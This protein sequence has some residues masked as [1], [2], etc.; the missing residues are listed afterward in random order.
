MEAIERAAILLLGVGEQQAAHI[1]K[2]MSSRQVE[3]VVK[4]MTELKDITQEQIDQALNEFTNAS[5][6][7]TSLG[8]DSSQYIRKTLMGA[9]GNERASLLIDR[10]LSD[11]EDDG[12]NMLK[13]QDAAAI[14]ALIRDEHPQVIAVIL[15]YLDSEKAAAVMQ[16]LPDSQRE[17]IMP[18]IASMRS[19]SPRALQALNQ[20]VEEGAKDI[21]S[22]K[23]LPAV[24]TRSAANILN[25]M[26][27]DLEDQMMKTIQKHD[28]QLAEK[29][30]EYMFPFEKLAD[31]DKRSLQT[32]LREV[33]NDTMVLALKG[34]DET[35]Q[36]AF[37]SNMS[38]RAADMLKDDLEAKG[39]V[40]LNKV[41]G[42]QKEI[43]AMA[44]RMAQDGAIVMGG[45]G[46]EMVG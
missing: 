24:G 28:E 4:K 6:L 23:P 26:G 35:I 46:E 30:Q 40:Q 45:A 5:Q 41:E 1:L 13:W 9:L 27:R 43:V 21:R 18:R 22:F 2:H 32:L 15:T 34:A 12:V 17:Q 31:L 11:S 10:T 25:F 7:N 3:T 39:P 42:A 36:K 44:Q 33:P 37:F 14:A 8:L 38:E 19:I 29:V 16:E 20:F